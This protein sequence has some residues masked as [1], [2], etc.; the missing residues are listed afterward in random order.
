MPHRTRTLSL[1]RHPRAIFGAALASCA[2]AGL[3]PAT[4]HAGEPQD[5]FR[6]EVDAPSGKG[7]ISSKKLETAVRKHVRGEPRAAKVDVR[8]EAADPG[9][10]WVA[11]V[12]VAGK[13][14]RRTVKASGASCSQLDEGLVLVVTLL[15]DPDE[16]TPDAPPKADGD[17]REGDADARPKGSWGD[18]EPAEE[19]PAA[20]PERP[21]KPAEPEPAEE[22]EK[23]APAEPAIAPEPANAGSKKEAPEPKQAVSRKR[24][25]QFGIGTSM[26]YTT[27]LLSVPAA[28][29][30]AAITWLQPTPVALEAAFTYHV[31]QGYDT[32]SG[33]APQILFSPGAT[34]VSWHLDA[35]T[36]ELNVCP[37]FDVWR[38]HL[39]VCGGAALT[40]VH[41]QEWNRVATTDNQLGEPTYVEYSKFIVSQTTDFRLDIS[42]ASF[43]RAGAGFQV[44]VPIVNSN[45]YNAIWGPGSGPSDRVAFQARGGLTLVLPP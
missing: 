44:L 15:A 12:T 25:A 42:L 19:E 26:V 38:L 41:Y 4:A 33:A 29:V 30:R 23:P 22:P 14:G 43:L 35:V 28:G 11:D 36:S 34:F 24:R 40:Y 17:K 3:A 5:G 1:C 45:D 39:G 18:E 6:V 16:D 37:K 9:P 13:T 2:V 20:R 27:G 21:A 31:P 7:C 32:M 8:V 10:G